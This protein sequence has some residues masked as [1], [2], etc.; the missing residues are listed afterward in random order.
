MGHVPKHRLVLHHQN[1][2]L[3]PANFR[4]GSHLNIRCF[5]GCGVSWKENGKYSPSSYFALNVN[6][7]TMLFGNAINSGQSEACSFAY[8]L[9]SKKGLKDAS[10]GFRIHAAATIGYL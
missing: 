7:A 2:L 5:Y 1:R 4:H 8:F 9:R 10:H 3:A 6:P